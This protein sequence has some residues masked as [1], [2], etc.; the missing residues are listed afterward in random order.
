VNDTPSPR[1]T[2]RE[3]VGRRRRRVRLTLDDGST[4]EVAPPVLEEHPVRVGDPV[5][6]AARARLLDAD[7]AWRCR[8]AGLRLLGVR[9]RSRQELGRRLRRATF[10]DRIVDG[11]LDALED[12]G[13]LDDAAFARAVVRDRVRFKPRAPVRLK[14]ELRRKGVARPV[15]E[16]AVRTVFEEEG[17]APLEL[18][19]EAALG[20]L[21]RQGSGTVAQLGAPEWSEDLE[22]VKR[23]LAA[24]LGRRGFRGSPAVTAVE[25]A[26]KAAAEQGETGG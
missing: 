8:N 12:E 24:Y 15:A 4:L 10:P 1:V 18:A 16:D 13:W 9:A 11:V 23:R 6:D 22:R 3:A 5:D 19:V 26:R 7:L 20:W 21:R 17:V 2:A 14:Q 25:A